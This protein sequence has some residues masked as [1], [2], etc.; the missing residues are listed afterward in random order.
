[1]PFGGH[2][3]GGPLGCAIAARC[4]HYWVQPL[5]K[6]KFGKLLHTNHPLPTYSGCCDL[7][8][9]CELDGF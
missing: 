5:M 8:H 7:G 3:G 1:M 9:L 4:Y 2:P 6:I